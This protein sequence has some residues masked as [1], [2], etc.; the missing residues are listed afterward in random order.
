MQ[1]NVSHAGPYSGADPSVARIQA[2]TAQLKSS[3]PRPAW[4]QHGDRNFCRWP[5]RFHYRSKLNH[6]HW[7][8]NV[9]TNAEPNKSSLTVEL[10]LRGSLHESAPWW[11]FS[12]HTQCL[13]SAHNLRHRLCDMYIKHENVMA[14][15]SHGHFFY[16]ANCVKIVSLSKTL[17]FFII[18]SLSIVV[19]LIRHENVMVWNS[20]RHFFYFANYVKIVSLPKTSAF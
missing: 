6:R 1:R 2:R 8:A 4:A 7:N 12:Q 13:S 14:W 16:F 20:H 10:L 17:T 18:M 9:G 19:I 11:E 5:H 15:H 3:I